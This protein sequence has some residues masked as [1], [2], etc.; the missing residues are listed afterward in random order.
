MESW[1]AYWQKPIYDGPQSLA[2][3]SM[4]SSHVRDFGTCLGHVNPP[5][6][7]AMAV[8][9]ESGSAVWSFR[10]DLQAS[11]CG[12]SSRDTEATKAC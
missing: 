3:V 5:L 6:H 8:A 1:R 2:T 7:G 11:T 10:S 9:G 4:G 12:T